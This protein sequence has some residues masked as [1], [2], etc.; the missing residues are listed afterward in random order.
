MLPI[1]TAAEVSNRL[2]GIPQKFWIQ[3][4]VAVLA[5]ILV[6]IALRK[7]AGM[8]KVVLGVI[9]LL[10]VSFVGFNWIYERTEPAWATPVIAKLAGFLPS[11]TAP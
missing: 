3:I 8:N 7:I 9:V 1:A 2:H 4:G 6:V 5:L 10:I 11:K